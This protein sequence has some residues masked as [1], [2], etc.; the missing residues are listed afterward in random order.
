[1]S[2]IF[3][4]GTSMNFLS[5][6]FTRFIGFRKSK[7]TLGPMAPTNHKT[8]RMRVFWK[9]AGL[10]PVTSAFTKLTAF[11]FTFS[12]ACFVIYVYT[13]RTNKNHTYFINVLI[14]LY[15]FWHVSNNQVFV[16][17]KSVQTAL[18]YFIIHLYKQSSYW[19]D[20]F[21]L[22]NWVKSLIKKCAS[23]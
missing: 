19:W 1:M 10:K 16:T 7:C 4:V 12:E 3:I 21:V 11:H 18:R 6:V 2:Y 9:P 13:R 20:V 15:C 14:Q 22:Y 23:C 8:P 17:R 5:A